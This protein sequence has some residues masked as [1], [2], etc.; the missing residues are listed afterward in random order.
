[1]SQPYPSIYKSNTSGHVF[2]AVITSLFFFAAIWLYIQPVKIDKVSNETINTFAIILMLITGIIFLVSILRILSSGPELEFT[3]E[4]FKFKVGTSSIVL[5]PWNT[6]Q[7]VSFI[8]SGK[9]I[10][11]A[12]HISNPAEIVRNS[13]AWAKLVLLARL[14]NY[15]TPV[16][17]SSKRLHTDSE[18]LKLAFVQYWNKFRHA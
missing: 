9:H 17:L 2:Q 10:L 3:Q 12:V 8:K 18:E 6:I 4:G 5:I 11:L 14:K 1:M 15:R 16:L 13:K 7:D